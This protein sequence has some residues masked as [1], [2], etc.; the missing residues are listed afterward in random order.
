VGLGRANVVAFQTRN[1]LHRAH[2]EMM[3]RAGREVDGTLLLHPVVGMTKAGDIDHYTRVR[4]Y[5]SLLQHFADPDRIILSLLP[6]AMRMAAHT[7]SCG[8]RCQPW[9]GAPAGRHKLAKLIRPSYLCRSLRELSSIAEN[10]PT[11]CAVG[12]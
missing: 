7:A 2:E 9:I 6:L 4:T 3:L 12:Y 8:Y 5:K 10:L 1:P 11:A